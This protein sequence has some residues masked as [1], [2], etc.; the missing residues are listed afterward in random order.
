MACCEKW[1]QV[2]EEYSVFDRPDISELRTKY[3]FK[4][5]YFHDTYVT[6]RISY[7]PFCGEKLIT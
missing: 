4:F 5:E 7:C 6:I 3:T 1:R 2:E